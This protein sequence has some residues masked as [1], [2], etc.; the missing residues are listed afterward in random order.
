MYSQ[1]IHIVEDMGYQGKLKYT[2]LEDRP[3]VNRQ[4]CFYAVLNIFELPM[5]DSKALYV[6]SIIILTV[7][8]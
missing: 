2:I 3:V 6:L 1:C 7:I 5:I 8:L 4:Y